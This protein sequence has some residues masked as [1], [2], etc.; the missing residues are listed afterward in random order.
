[1]H[2]TTPTIALVMVA[3]LQ[4][5]CAS[6]R[7]A[8]K[9]V[10]RV[11]VDPAQRCERDWRSSDGLQPA[12]AQGDPALAVGA[13]TLD[14]LDEF[15]KLV[16]LVNDE[17]FDPQR[18][19][20]AKMLEAIAASIVQASEGALTSDGRT[21][22]AADGAR[23]PLPETDS[24]WRLPLALRDLGGF[25][26][27]HL[28]A[29]HRLVKG[30][31]AEILAANALLSTLDPGSILVPKSVLDSSR[32]HPL[33]V[34]GSPG[35][36]ERAEAFSAMAFESRTRRGGVLHLRVGPMREQTP[37]L[38]RAALE[39]A[40]GAGL[41]LDLRGNIGGL[42]E[43]AKK[44]AD[45][46]LQ[47][48]T[49]ATFNARESAEV[50]TATDDHLAS[51]RQ[52]LVVLVDA[53]T[54]SGGEMVAGAL[55]FSN[56]AILVGERTF[57]AGRIQVQYDFNDPRNRGDLLRLSIAEILLPGD[58]AFDGRGIAPDLQV[59]DM[60]VLQG[61]AGRRCAPVGTTAAAADVSD[62]DPALAY[63]LRVIELAP[64]AARS[65]L[66]AAAKSLAAKAAV[67]ERRRRLSPLPAL[68]APPPW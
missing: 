29:R 8:A 63:A 65:D 36:Q 20:P 51:E 11:H 34:E 45:L 23:W 26:V 57:G 15:R 33:T 18:V 22:A 42:F 3:I 50:W 35:D 40:S 25:L 12:I 39:R 68:P 32:D 38:M 41:I 24:I 13:T 64:S 14:R 21:L 56:R 66:L 9:P 1:M 49:I 17:Y 30:R 54:A 46:F 2:S 37:P 48:G 58:L 61:A 59:T 27:G 67:S 6:G 19:R 60:P 62:P 4:A 5:A 53:M 28:P 10:S 16:V 55:R 43:A 52:K 44:I 7:S 31:F 47:S